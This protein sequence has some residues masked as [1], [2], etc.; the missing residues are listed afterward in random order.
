MHEE[1]SQIGL[2]AFANPEQCLLTTVVCSHGTPSQAANS[3]P[4]RKAA[5][6]FDPRRGE[7]VV[8]RNLNR[9]YHF[10]NWSKRGMGAGWPPTVAHFIVLLRRFPSPSGNARSK[11]P[12]TVSQESCN[13]PSS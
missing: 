5:P 2:P 11:S 8:Y 12:M 7:N 13:A 6:L 3:R 4:L 1:S 10:P 9:A